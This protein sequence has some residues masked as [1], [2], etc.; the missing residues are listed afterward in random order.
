MKKLLLST[1]ILASSFT[2]FAQI[3]KDSLKA[4][5]KFNSNTDDN[6]G[7]GKN[8]IISGSGVTLT[9]DRSNN[10]N[11]AYNFDGVDGDIS[12]NIGEFKDELTISFWYSSATQTQPY[13]HF[14]DYGDYKVR[15]HI[16]SGSIY[17]TTDRNAIY[18]ESYNPS[19]TVVKGSQK[20]GDNKWT[21]VVVSFSKSANELKLYVNGVLDQQGSVTSNDLGLSDG[22]IVFGRVRTGSPSNVNTTRFKGKMDDIFIYN[23]TLTQTEITSLFDG[24][25]VASTKTVDKP[26][27]SVYPNPFSSELNLNLPSTDVENTSYKLTDITGKI[28]SEGV[29]TNS[30]STSEL[31][32]GVYLLSVYQND[33]FLGTQKVVKQ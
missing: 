18:L 23:R 33:S 10:A 24:D 3:P 30:I 15:C 22:I 1:L 6:S 29:Y 9:T 20:P 5:F 14:F 25:N 19:A 31:S 4:C 27:F 2:I 16:M 7:N 21:H 26:S 32:T 8:A 28:I 17:N 13:P 11:S 12:A